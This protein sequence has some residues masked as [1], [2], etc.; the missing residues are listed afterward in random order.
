[1]SEEE[2]AEI[3]EMDSPEYYRDGIWIFPNAGGG[4]TI[5]GDNG[6]AAFHPSRAGEICEVIM[7]MAEFAQRKFKSQKF[8]KDKQK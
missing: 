3:L 2:I 8:I 4:V 7:A 1:M 6:I 5:E